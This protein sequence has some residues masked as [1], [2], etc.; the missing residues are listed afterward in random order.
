MFKI[1]NFFVIIL[2]LMVN[3]V[4]NASNYPATLT[5]SEAASRARLS[6]MVNSVEGI[7]Y[8]V[9]II[10]FNEYQR[11]KWVY[12]GVLGGEYLAYISPVGENTVR[13]QNISLFGG[14]SGKAE[15]FEGSINPNKENDEGI[16]IAKGK[17]GLPDLLCSKIRATGGG[18]FLEKIFIIKNSSLKNVRFIDKNQ[19]IAVSK[20]TGFERTNYL[21]RTLG[22]VK[23]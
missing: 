3:S 23:L 9:Y 19:A 22:T 6:F 16:Y 8:D 1:K 14:W 7:S 15:T 10:G 13:V 4:C 17:R 2:L 5:K 18:G 11:Q 21:P 20:A 12:E